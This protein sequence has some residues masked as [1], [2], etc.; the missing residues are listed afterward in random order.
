M[1]DFFSIGELAG[2][3]KISKQ[4]LIFYDKIDLF[5]PAYTHPSNRLSVLQ[6]H[7]AGYIRH[8]YDY[9]NHRLFA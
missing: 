9:E 2:Y 1:K 7:A 6:R 3:Q 8:N 4:T 5:K